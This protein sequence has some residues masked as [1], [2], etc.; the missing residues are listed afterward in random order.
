MKISIGKKSFDAVLY[1]NPTAD[2]FKKMLPITLYMTELNGNEKYA[3]LPNNLST[4]PSTPGHIRAGDL[5]IFGSA[6][7]VLF[8]KSFQ[9]PYSYTI[10]GKI[11]DISGLEQAV[12]KGNVHVT[13]ELK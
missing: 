9:S 1:D 10:L 2:H 7:L 8:Y 4:S 5:M 6:T 3:D 13:F 11:D 12:G